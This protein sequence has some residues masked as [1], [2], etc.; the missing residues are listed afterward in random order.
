MEVSADSLFEAAALAVVEF[1]KAG[2]VKSSLG[3]ATLL[4]VLSYPDS[5]KRYSLTFGR[6]ENWARTGTCR[7]PR[8]KV[9]RDRIAEMLGITRD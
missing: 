4:R 9:Y 2:L 3:G 5:P 1:R 8:E 7:S 6:L